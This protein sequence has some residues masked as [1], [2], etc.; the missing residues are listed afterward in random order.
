MSFNLQPS[1]V[2]SQTFKFLN[3]LSV[4]KSIVFLQELKKL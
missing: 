3:N 1:S 4:F 2:L